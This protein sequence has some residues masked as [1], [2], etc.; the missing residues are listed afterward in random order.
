MI[1]LYTSDLNKI[2]SFHGLSNSEIQAHEGK[3]PQFLEKIYAR[4]QGFYSDEVIDNE[5]VVQ[6]I[7]DYV[8]SV[9][10]KY[11][12]I[13]VL[14]IGGSS[15]GMICLKEAFGNLFTG[16]TPQV[17]VLDNIDPSFL[18]ECED[19]LDLSKTLFIPITKSGGTPETLSQYFYFSGKLKQAGLELKEHMVCITGPEGF[20]REEVEA[21]GMHSFSVPPTVGGRFSVLTPVGLLPAALAGIDIR[22]LLKGA[23][24]MREKFLSEDLEQN[25][26][27]QLAT[28]QY[29]L[30]EKGK[31]MNVMMPYSQKLYRLADWY[32][33]LLAESIGKKANEQGETVHTG[34]TPVNALGVTDQHS[35]TQLYMEGPNDKLFLFLELEDFGVDMYIP[36]PHPEDSR[37]N[38]IKNTSF[39]KLILTEKAGTAEALTKNDRPH[40]TIK[41]PKISEEHMGELFMLFEAATAFLG[42]YYEI[43]A[44]DQPGVELSKNL[45]KELLMKED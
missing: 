4:N 16:T 44:F 23:R 42:E 7:E 33:Q 19:H 1:S 30:A 27:F 41:I 11:D 8:K 26:P 20:L 18:K 2:S 25:L 6:E 9:K 24:N 35:Q 32:R 17:H 12:H 45:T 34:I 5:S 39:K 37:V 43:N 21:H 13:I 14:G 22:G 10:G 28:I 40:L 36:L 29:L 15:L 31:V 38:F 3:I